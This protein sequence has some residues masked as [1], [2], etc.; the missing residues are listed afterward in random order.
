MTTTTAARPL[1]KW[2][3]GK[4]QL[5]PELLKRVPAD[6]DVYHEPFLGGG[7]MFFALRPK[8]AI[9]SDINA[10]LV[11]VYQVVARD[12]EG[13]IRALKLHRYDE[14]YYYGVRAQDREETFRLLSPVT[15]AA[16]FIFINKTGYNG[17]WRVNS[18]GAM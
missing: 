14:A 16:R 10:E 6:F 7:A 12:V 1:L 4:T 2:V 3:G 18:R 9:L 11:N 5:L 15:R 8:V 13:L 17:L